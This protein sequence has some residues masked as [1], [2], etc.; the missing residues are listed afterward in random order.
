MRKEF[1]ILKH[2]LKKYTK[3]TLSFL[4]AF[5]ISGKVINAT[6]IITGDINKVVNSNFINKGSFIGETKGLEL[7]G[8]M[9]NY[10]VIKG[11]NG[12]GLETK[13][14]DE[15]Y[16]EGLILGG[17]RTDAYLFETSGFIENL[18]GDV[19]L[20][21][22]DNITLDT[23]GIIKGVNGV[24]TDAKTIALNN[25][26]KILVDKVAINFRGSEVEANVENYGII[27]GNIN[28]QNISFDNNGVINGNINSEDGI[29][30]NFGVSNSNLKGD[31][32][33]KVNYGVLSGENFNLNV[34]EGL[35]IKTKN[36]VIE[37]V[38]TGNDGEYKP[39]N[40]KI[41]NI[42][43]G[44][45]DRS[46]IAP[47]VI[48]KEIIN[49]VGLN[50]GS[51]VVQNRVDI[52][53]SILNAYGTTVYLE[54]SG[55]LNAKDVT[56]N[57]GKNIAIK[58]DSSNNK[59][60]IIG[61]SYING[62][63]DLGEGDD[64]LLIS[65]NDITI[66]GDLKGGQGIDKLTF[67]GDEKNFIFNNIKEFESL[68]VNG[69]ISLYEIAHIEN[70]NINLNKGEL[71]LR[72]N[73]TLRDSNNKI[74]GHA[75]YNG[76][77]N[78]VNATGTGKLVIGLNGI[79]ENTVLSMLG[80]TIKESVNDSWWKETDHLVT[81]SSVL[82]AKLEKNGDIKITIKES[83]PTNA[84]LNNIYQSIVDSKEIGKLKNT[85]S[86]LDKTDKESMDRLINLLDKID[87]NNPYT[88]TLKTSRDSMASF[89]DEIEYLTIK[90]KKDEWIVQA[91][92]IGGEI[93][94]DV[95]SKVRTN[96]F[97]G[98][99]SAE[100]GITDSSSL[101]I[102]IGGNNQ[103][104]DFRGSSK[105]DADSMYVG[106]FG[107]TEKNSFKVMTGLGY[108]Y[109]HA[110]GERGASNEYDSFLGDDNYNINGFN[111]FLELKYRYQLN[112]EWSLEPKLKFTYFYV[113]Q[114]KINEGYNPVGINI[115]TDRGY[116]NTGAFEFGKSI[117]NEKYLSKGRLK[118]SLTLGIVRNFGDLNQELNGRVIGRDG[119]GE[120]FKI[121]G[122]KINK[123]VGKLSYD[124]EYEKEIGVIYTAGVR[125][126]FGKDEYRNVRATVGVGYRF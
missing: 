20:C 108:Q 82:D 76:K 125:F 35:Y 47:S 51:L 121:G 63:I 89:V 83:I 34:N 123:G 70:S 94:S 7:D 117:I 21:T 5:L 43:T 33:F 19:L 46:M 126:E 52:S 102:V 80:T 29:I 24:V 90:P 84:T 38:T 67:E 91:K 95:D 18:K 61:D 74:I 88:Y 13:N 50:K 60:S 4:V 118:N 25:T 114:E 59:V 54:K 105:I 16:N 17:V 3:I 110:K 93:R 72:V 30:N 79:G 106:V 49:G 23:E 85:T 68:N 62:D 73:P 44:G 71:L 66:N 81:D 48:N 11:I 31:N 1:K 111:A 103:D 28:S 113:E 116:A 99:A 96:M 56:F 12:I 26:G 122:A 15:I 100:Y 36:G 104:T 40:L 8:S 119:V 57:S 115:E 58:G 10:G 124:L 53:G 109:T 6:N 92:G 97:G 112:K 65:S 2:Y 55:E 22:S 86:L 107:K 45:L 41:V 101:G 42:E 37:S 64:S 14:S 87:K 69:D 9:E 120:S 75:L 39:L 27:K 78:T 32:L 98:L 77:G